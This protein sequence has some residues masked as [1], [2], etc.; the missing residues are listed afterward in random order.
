MAHH[1]QSIALIL[2]TFLVLFPLAFTKKAE[3]VYELTFFGRRLCC[4][5]TWP[6]G[7][8]PDSENDFNVGVT[9][10]MAAFK[11]KNKIL[12]TTRTDNGWFSFVFKGCTNPIMKYDLIEDC[13]IIVTDARNSDCPNLSV[14]LISHVVGVPTDGIIDYANNGDFTNPMETGIGSPSPAPAPY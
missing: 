14:P 7:N 11:C 6:N 9:G 2:A 12:N 4:D 3:N 13:V 10:A 5:D 1:Y 8:C